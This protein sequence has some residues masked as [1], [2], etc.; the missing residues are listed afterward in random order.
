MTDTPAPVPA[1]AQVPQ[2]L[3]LA[4]ASPDSLTEL[5]SRDP[6]RLAET[7]LQ[8]IIDELR[9]NRERLAK[10]QAEPRQAKRVTSVK[11]LV[12]SAAPDEL[13]L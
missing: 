8:R 10:A 5:F 7:D 9:K 12:S 3:A 4:E 13:D 2:S 6:E 1:A 11:S